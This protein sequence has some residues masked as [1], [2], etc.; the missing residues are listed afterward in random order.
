[1]ATIDAYQAPTP[2]AETLNAQQWINEAIAPDSY[3][4]APSAINHTSLWMTVYESRPVQINSSRRSES[5]SRSNPIASLDGLTSQTELGKQVEDNGSVNHYPAIDGISHEILA[6]QGTA[7][8]AVI[9][10]MGFYLLANGN[11]II[12]SNLGNISAAA[13]LLNQLGIANTNICHS[14]IN[15]KL[16]VH[17]YYAMQRHI[18]ILQS[19]SSLPS[20]KHLRARVLNLLSLKPH[21]Y[22]YCPNSS[23]C[24]CYAGSYATL[25]ECL[26]CYLPRNQTGMTFPYVPLVPRLQ[27]LFASPNTRQAMRYHYKLPVKVDDVYQHAVGGY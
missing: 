20:L 18:C 22:K 23:S 26:K 25:S 9:K 12:I 21:D 27:A 7:A 19:H 13:R 24:I 3:N 2:P 4:V 15:S 17:T 1:M 16:S 6:G 11:L 8:R 5:D 14:I 10:G